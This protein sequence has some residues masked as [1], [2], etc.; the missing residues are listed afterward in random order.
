MQQRTLNSGRRF[1]SSIGRALPT[2]YFKR[3]VRVLLG[4]HPSNIL[5]GFQRS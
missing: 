2:P 4:S 5:R 1:P 3:F